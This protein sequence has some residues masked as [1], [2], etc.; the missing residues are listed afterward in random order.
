MDQEQM[1]VHQ[2]GNSRMIYDASVSLDHDRVNNMMNYTC[3]SY[4]KGI[5]T[6]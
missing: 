5:S 1:N 6:R 4:L 3:T 2:L